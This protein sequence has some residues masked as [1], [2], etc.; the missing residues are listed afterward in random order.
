MKRRAF[1]ESRD[2]GISVILFRRGAGGNGSLDSN[3]HKGCISSSCTTNRRT[4]ERW[5]TCQN[6]NPSKLL[7]SSLPRK[8]LESYKSLANHS[9]DHMSNTSFAFFY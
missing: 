2:D 6:P 3:M 8:I 4:W 7:F 9:I 5:V 1:P